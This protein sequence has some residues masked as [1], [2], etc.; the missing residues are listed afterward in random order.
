MWIYDQSLLHEIYVK[1]LY[2]ASG[3]SAAWNMNMMAGAPASI[4]ELR[5]RVT[6]KAE[7]GKSF[8]ELT[9]PGLFAYFPTS[10]I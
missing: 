6:P 10:L 1:V 3:K 8:I 5:I 2:A 7:A 9:I 4:L